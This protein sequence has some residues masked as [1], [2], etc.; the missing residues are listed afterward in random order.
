MREYRQQAAWEWVEAWISGHARLVGRGGDPRGPGWGIQAGRV[1]P[2][3]R[4][5]GGKTAEGA[6]RRLPGGAWY[7]NEGE[8]PPPVQ[9]VSEARL[10]GT[11]Q[12]IRAPRPATSPPGPVPRVEGSVGNG[13][14]GARC[15][16]QGGQQ[17]PPALVSEGARLRFFA[18]VV[19]GRKPAGSRAAGRLR[20]SPTRNSTRTRPRA[21]P[22]A[23]GAAAGEGGRRRASPEPGAPPRARMQP[24]AATMPAAPGLRRRRGA[25]D[26]VR[27]DDDGDMVVPT[28][29]SAEPLLGSAPAEGGPRPR[30]VAPTV[31]A[32]LWALVNTVFQAGTDHEEGELARDGGT[33]VAKLLAMPAEEVAS[34]EAIVAEVSCASYLAGCIDCNLQ[35]VELPNI[36]LHCR[37]HR[38]KVR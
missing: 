14:G 19:W 28:E 21:A 24:R 33:H 4:L 17:Q 31:E 6:S 2:R 32:V 25:P 12:Y 35:A 10:G 7:R 1:I 18:A 22:G 5:V 23:A 36:P 13:T 15:R 27:G 37:G 16:N 20:A 34:R 26:Q 11:P 9:Q 29:D 30:H 8:A 3:S 38:G